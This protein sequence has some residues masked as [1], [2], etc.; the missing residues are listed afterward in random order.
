MIVQ[1]GDMRDEISIQH[2]ILTP[3]QYGAQIESWQEFARVRAYMQEVK[4][5]ETTGPGQIRGIKT[6][7]FTIR[8][9]EATPA[10]RVLFGGAWYGILETIRLDAKGRWTKITAVEITTG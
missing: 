9:V 2:A 1:A 4:G 7:W 5:V 8:T 6:V 3:D 10:M